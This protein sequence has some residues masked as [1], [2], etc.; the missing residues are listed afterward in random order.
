MVILLAVLV[1]CTGAEEPK[2]INPFGKNT[3]PENEREGVRPGYIETSDG[4]VFPGFIYLTRDIRL[5]MYDAEHQRKRAIPLERVAS[6]EAVVKKEWM[7]KEW[8]F[9]ELASNEKL[10]TGREYPVRTLHPLPNLRISRM[11]K[12]G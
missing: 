12:H 10:Y 1:P 9:K 8:R 6:L 7:E 4:E 3:K 2:A 11:I 5:S